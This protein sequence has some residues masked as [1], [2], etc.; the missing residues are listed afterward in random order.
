MLRSRSQRGRRGQ[1][2]GVVRFASGFGVT[3]VLLEKEMLAKLVVDSAK[4]LGLAAFPDF[5]EA[6][7]LLRC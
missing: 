4:S 3:E 1:Y 2:R 6:L 7:L 5:S